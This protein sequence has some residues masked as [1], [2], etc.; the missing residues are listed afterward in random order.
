MTEWKFEIFDVNGAGEVLK[1]RWITAPTEA[2]AEA[3]RHHY[4]RDGWITNH[5][6]PVQYT[7]YI[8]YQRARLEKKR[9]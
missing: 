2:E 6:H 9:T 1:H 4:D 5:P 8:A 7:N 3:K